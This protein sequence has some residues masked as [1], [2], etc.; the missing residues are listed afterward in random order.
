[1][2]VKSPG[3][4]L[5]PDEKKFHKERRGPLKIVYSLEGALLVMEGYD[6]VRFD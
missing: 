5:T 6:R 3:G 2:E 1:M 4:K